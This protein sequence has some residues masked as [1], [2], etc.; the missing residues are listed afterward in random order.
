MQGVTHPY[1][2]VERQLEIFF[3]CI[4]RRQTESTYLTTRKI[5]QIDGVSAGDVTAA[6]HSLSEF[7]D[8]SAREIGTANEIPSMLQE[9]RLCLPKGGRYQ[10]DF[11][12][13][14]PPPGGFFSDAAGV[15]R[16]PFLRRFLGFAIG[17]MRL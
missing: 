11:R 10:L 16:R 17:R 13:S 7:P 6:S 1:A 8:Q 4:V 15:K 5:S 9:M 2:A 14:E 12:R 3:G